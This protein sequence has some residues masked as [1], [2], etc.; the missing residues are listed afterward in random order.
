MKLL[1]I[2]LVVFDIPD[3]VIVTRAVGLRYDPTTNKVYHLKFDPPPKNNAIE[4][5][6]IRKASDTEPA[7]K[8][9]VAIFRKNL[10][11]LVQSFQSQNVN[12][13]KFPN[14]FMD[15]QEFIYK[16]IFAILGRK[17]IT[18]APRSFKLCILGIPGS[19]KTKLAEKL[20]QKYGFAHGNLI[21]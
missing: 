1:K 19:G 21:L 16:D 2:L 3:D 10:N 15:N 12:V 17:S 7:T 20:A 9:R 14:G 11:E 13:L 18:R 4:S 5:R 8:A 6:L